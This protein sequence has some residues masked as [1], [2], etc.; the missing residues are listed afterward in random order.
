MAC[1]SVLWLLQQI[2]GLLSWMLGLGFVLKFTSSHKCFCTRCTM[3]SFFRSVTP[4]LPPSPDI[5]LCMF[6]GV[7]YG[8]VGEE[9]LH[10]SN[11]WSNQRRFLGCNVQRFVDYLFFTK[12]YCNHIC[13]LLWKM[14][15]YSETR[16]GHNL[17]CTKVMCLA[18]LTQ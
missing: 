4:S 11:C 12:S 14:S 18:Y 2:S 1:I 17:L 9:L 16:V 10:N 13:F 15:S 5:S 7:D 6:A 8:A 3:I